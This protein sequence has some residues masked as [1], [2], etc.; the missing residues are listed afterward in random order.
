LKL[1]VGRNYMLA[2][3][4]FASRKEP[5]KGVRL[6]LDTLRVEHH[7]AALGVLVQGGATET[8]RCSSPDT[9]YAIRSHSG[10]GAWQ[11]FGTK[12]AKYLD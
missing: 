10:P 9:G 11:R 1:P 2:V 12:G 8:P 3:A 7:R 5:F 6:V 4:R